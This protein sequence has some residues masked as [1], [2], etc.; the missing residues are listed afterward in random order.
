MN[1]LSKQLR[2]KADM[3]EMGERIAWGSD[4]R[5]M[6]EAAD[7]LEQTE[8]KVLYDALDRI[9]WDEINAYLDNLREGQAINED[10]GGFLIRC[11]KGLFG[12]SPRDPIVTY[13]NAAKAL[14]EEAMKK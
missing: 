1:E 8:R 5:L 13:K 14:V 11:I 4:S 12:I 3:I 9:G 10:A 7:A 2:I 6:R